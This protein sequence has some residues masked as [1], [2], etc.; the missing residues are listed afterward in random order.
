[1]SIKILCKKIPRLIVRNNNIVNSNLIDSFYTYN[2]KLKEIAK[3][4]PGY[5]NSESYFT[6]YN[7]IEK[8]EIVLTIS[9]WNKYYDWDNWYNS[10]ERMELKKEYDDIIDNEII[11]VLF[12]NSKEYD[13]FLL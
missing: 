6:Y 4:M 7:T 12:K 8:Q 1:M 13:T 3:T 10:N 9:E 11:S 5:I 2:S